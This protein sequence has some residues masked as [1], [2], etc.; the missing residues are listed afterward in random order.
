MTGQRLEQLL[1][2]CTVRLTTG[3][4]HGT[5]F[6]VAPG[7]ILTCAHVVEMAKGKPVSVFWKAHQQTYVADVVKCLTDPNIDLALLTLTPPLPDHPCVSLDELM[8][9][10]GDRLYSFGYPQDNPDGD[11]VTSGFEGESFRG[12]AS[13]HKLKGGQFNYGSSGSPLLNCRTGRVCGVVAIS[14]NVSTDL[15]ARAIPAWVIFSQLPELIAPHQQFHQTHLQWTLAALGSRKFTRH[16]VLAGAMGAGVAL[17]ILRAAIAPVFYLQP[18]TV[19]F[20]NF[21]GGAVLGAAL[22]YGVVWAEDLKQSSPSFWISAI[23]VETA[24]FGVAHLMLAT[25]L[26]G[27]WLTHAPLVIPMG[28]VAGL[29]LSLAVH[30][31]SKLSFVEAPPT[32]KPS[33]HSPQFWIVRGV[34]RDRWFWRLGFVALVFACI[35]SIFLWTNL[36]SGLVIIWS[37]QMYEAS[38]NRY[39]DLSWWAVWMQWWAVWMQR[40]PQWFNRLTIFDYLAIIDSALMGMA[41]AIGLMTGW[42]F[43]N[44]RLIKQRT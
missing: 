32:R 41:L 28:F 34:F 7:L 24:S 19:F 6:F 36:G 13:L 3:G 20:H 16:R 10:L 39:A 44:D 35:Q 2:A 5:G 17:G 37:S 23:A 43:V 29:G 9:Q 27:A 8:P 1:Q 11:P 42:Q 30:D 38:L 31:Q 12:G 33:A 18:F 22:T 25:L 15:G 40:C 21:W 4:G 14:R 26:G